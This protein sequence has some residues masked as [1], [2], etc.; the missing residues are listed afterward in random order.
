MRNKQETFKFTKQEMLQV[1]GEQRG[2]RIIFTMPVEF[3][4]LTSN[5]MGIELLNAMVD[6]FVEDGYLLQDLVYTPVE[7]RGETIYIEVDALATD[8]IRG[9]IN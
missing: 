8:W 7:M 4:E 3:D 2:Q 9:S 6:E 1:L 5:R